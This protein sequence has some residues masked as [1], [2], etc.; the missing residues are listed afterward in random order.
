MR[1]IDLARDGRFALTARRFDSCHRALGDI[2][3]A[4]HKDADKRAKQALRRRA[5]NRTLRS[6]MRN[7]IKDVRLAIT[8]K[9]PVK[10]QEELRE[11]MSVIQRTAAKGV[12]HPN[13]AARRISRLHA[14]VK[15]LSQG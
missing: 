9:D 6:R 7:Q 10:A 5:R 1:T 15:R 13:Q 3:L 2:D 11:A 14:H 4:N 12:I 8:S